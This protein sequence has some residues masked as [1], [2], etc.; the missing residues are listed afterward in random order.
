[1]EELRLFALKG[2]ADEL[3][4]PAKDKESGGKHPE[5]VIENGGD[6]ERKRH[7]DQRNTKA[8]AE[9]VYWM[10][11]A[12]RV[13]CDPL[14]AAAST[15]HGRIITQHSYCGVSRKTRVGPACTWLSAETS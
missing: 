5:R 3:E 13:L 1:M 14:F 4:K 2:M 12:T 9:P 15:K 10:S 7:H 11:M 6:R 8:M